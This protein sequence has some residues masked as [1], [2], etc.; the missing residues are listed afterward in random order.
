[1]PRPLRALGIRRILSLLVPLLSGERTN[2]ARV[3]TRLGEKAFL[4]E[5]TR[6]LNL[7]WWDEARSHDAAADALAEQLGLAA[8]MAPGDTVLDVGFGFGDQDE[9]WLRRFQPAR[10]VG[11]NV[12]PLH[13]DAARRRF[14]DPRLDF[15]HG[16]ATA[17]ALPDAAADRVTALECAFHFVTREDF[18]REAF[19]VLKDGSRLATADVLPRPGRWPLT[20]RALVA[21]LRAFFQIPS[22]NWYDRDAYRRKLE[23]T[24]FV[25]VEVRSVREQVLLPF[26]DA[27]RRLLRSPAGAHVW[28]WP[29][30]QAARVPSRWFDGIDYVIASARR[31]PRS[32]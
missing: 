25:D 23:E 14:P 32:G 29:L 31:P 3:Y 11:L 15:R 26:W 13:V 5:R 12:T 17:M 21:Y 6:Y 2:A 27:T 18:F 30:R 7:G 19:R 4:G 24:G 20:A 28:S 10:I 9:Y 8:G 16:S 22:E 1:M